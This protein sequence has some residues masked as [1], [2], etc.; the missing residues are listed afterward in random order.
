LCCHCQLLMRDP[1]Q[2]IEC[3]HKF[4]R[5][6]FHRLL[7]RGIVKCPECLKAEKRDGKIHTLGEPWKYF[8]DIATKKEILNLPVTCHNSDCSWS[9][10]LRDL[11]ME[12]RLQC[13]EELI[14]CPY[15]VVGC[16]KKHQHSLRAWIKLRAWMLIVKRFVA[17]LSVAGG[18]G[19]CGWPT[20]ENSKKKRITRKEKDDHEK[21]SVVSHQKY[22][23][24]SFLELYTLRESSV[25]EEGKL[26]PHG[27]GTQELHGLAK[28]V[29]EM[30]RKQKTLQNI[31]AVFSRE[32]SKAEPTSV[33]Q[34][35]VKEN[36]N[37][38]AVLEKKVRNLESLMVLKD[39]AMANL[40]SHLQMLEQTSFDG[41]YIWKIPSVSQ[42]V[43]NVILHRNKF[44]Y[45]PPFYTG[46]YGYKL[47]LKVFLN[48]DGTGQGT[49]LSVFLVIMKGEYDFQLRWPFNHKVTF[50]LLDQVN[51]QHVSASFRPVNSNSFQ[52][53]TTEMNMGS[54]LPEFFPLDKL[55]SQ[56]SGYIRDDTICLKVVIDTVEQ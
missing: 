2:N 33:L 44:I 3:G 11:E 55:Y 28:K 34:N 45:S 50:L 51:Q 14:E 26:G 13:T 42:K 35:Q 52:R 8:P 25:S 19:V 49:N 36:S 7:S 9:G 18:G 6:C 53:P 47:C 56:D 23:L 21:S 30:E 22:L 41:T 43:K 37:R 20:M 5:E 32:L 46:K 39:M 24:E 4:C 38:A 16:Q 29:G 17:C 10:T 1:V 27:V 54:G 40:T 15:K 31:L 48:G 12:H